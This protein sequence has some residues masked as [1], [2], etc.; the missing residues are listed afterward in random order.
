MKEPDDRLY[1]LHIE[2][3]IQRIERC[4]VD[5]HDGFIESKMAQDS[6][7]SNFEV[8]GE[9]D[10]QISPSLLRDRYGGKTPDF[11]LP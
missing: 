1:L 11:A 5:G 7:I 10:K 9:A 6:V 2:D 8:I 4:G 3:R